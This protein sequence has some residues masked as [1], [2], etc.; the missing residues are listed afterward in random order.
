MMTGGLTVL[1]WV[2]Y[3]HSFKD[4]YEIIPGFFLALIVNLLV[5]KLTY[6]PD[7]EIDKEFDEVKSE[8]EEALKRIN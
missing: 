4:W 7:S 3:D 1:F 2:Y 5:S 6:K 8:T